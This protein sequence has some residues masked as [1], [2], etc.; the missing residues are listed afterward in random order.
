MLLVGQGT[1]EAVGALAGVASRVMCCEQSAYAPAT[2]AGLL[3][4]LLAEIDVVVLANAPGW[5]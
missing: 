3:A 2:W 5:S 4:P 1:A